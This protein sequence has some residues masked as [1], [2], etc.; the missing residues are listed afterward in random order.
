MGTNTK[1]QQV[2]YI[3]FSCLDTQT[4][5]SKG[6]SELNYTIE[7]TNS[8]AIYS[9]VTNTNFSQKL[10]EHSLRH[11]TFKS[12]N[13]ISKNTKEKKFLNALSDLI[14]IKLEISNKRNFT[15]TIHARDVT[16]YH[17]SFLSFF[18]AFN[19][20]RKSLGYPRLASHFLCS[21]SWPWTSHPLL[22][23]A[24]NTDVCHHTQLV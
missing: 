8:T 20:L 6:T 13:Q 17:F 7:P 5:S 10:I 19:F 12:T 3:P 21:Q 15:S 11:N 16:M 2:T 14:R 4:I 22:I 18:F 9:T 1:F 24:E 23:S